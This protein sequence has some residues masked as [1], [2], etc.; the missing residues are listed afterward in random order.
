LGRAASR[1]RIIPPSRDVNETAAVIDKIAF[2]S[3][4]KPFNVV[5]E[6]LP[7]E[8]SRSDWTPLELFVA[9]VRGGVF[10]PRAWPPR[11]SLPLPAIIFC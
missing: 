3:S 8:G 9:G 7:S 1:E 11:A 4:N 2:S 10:R 5:A 6:G